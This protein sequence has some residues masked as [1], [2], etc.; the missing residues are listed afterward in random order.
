MCW[1]LLVIPK[2]SADPNSPSTHYLRTLGHVG[3][4]KAIKKDYLDPYET[5]FVGCM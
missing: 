4:P 3:V 5:Y 1:V 2:R